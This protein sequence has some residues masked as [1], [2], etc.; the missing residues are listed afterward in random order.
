MSRRKNPRIT[1]VAW[2]PD[3][4]LRKVSHMNPCAQQ[5]AKKYKLED[6]QGA[7]FSNKAQN[8]FR[9]VANVGGMPCLILPPVGPRNLLISIW[10]MVSQ[11]LRYSSAWGLPQS[12]S[13]DLLKVEEQRRKA[14]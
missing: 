12:F 10:L 6:G 7:L 11:T 3:T 9:I 14:G 2:E 13:H 4:D 8:R 1:L 5:I